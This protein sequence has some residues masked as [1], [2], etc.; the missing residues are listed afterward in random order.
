MYVRI[1]DN[2]IVERTMDDHDGDAGWKVVP[3][4]AEGKLL[5]YDTGTSSVRAKTDAEN[6]TELDSLVLA[7]AWQ[8]LRTQRDTRLDNTDKFMMSDR[9]ATTN[10]PEY[11]EYLRDLPE[12]YSDVSI[13]SQ[14]AVMDFDAYVASL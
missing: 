8:L 2:K 13:M 3:A 14:T 7:E 4:E 11:R 1:V 9:T 10:M 6:A 12:E 5:K